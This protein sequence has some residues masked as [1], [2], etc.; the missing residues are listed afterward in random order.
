MTMG[1]PAY[2]SPE[3]ARGAPVD[4][5]ADLYSLGV[6]AFLLLSGRVPYHAD[7]A[8][9]IGI[10]HL[11]EDNTRLPKKLRV[12]QPVIDRAMA[13]DPAQRYQTGG[14]LIADLKAIPSADIVLAMAADDRQLLVDDGDRTSPTM[15]SPLPF[16]I[17]NREFAPA[18]ET[19]VYLSHE[20]LILSDED[21]S[22][23]VVDE[24]ADRR[25]SPR[26]WGW[27]V[28]LTLLAIGGYIWYVSQAITPRAGIIHKRIVELQNQ[29]STPVTTASEAISQADSGQD[30]HAG[31]PEDEA[32][33]EP[34]T[35][36]T[37]RFEPAP[38]TAEW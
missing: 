4:H 17:D 11:T 7:S 15:V 3:Q 34:A 31:V 19:E 20:S 9:A 13:K 24:V 21:R 16:N 2:M 25:S 29:A 30:F 35:G 27:L 18:Q 5:R 23:D 6:V 10:K 38:E 26:L 36:P 22:G 14:E 12:F 8:V 1:T 33:P 37:P 32:L 28:V